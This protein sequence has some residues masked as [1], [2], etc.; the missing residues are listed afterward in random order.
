MAACTTPTPQL[1]VDRAAIVDEVAHDLE[2]YLAPL[3]P[4]SSDTAQD[5]WQTSESQKCSARVYL[6]LQEGCAANLYR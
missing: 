1:T 4:E 2:P 6:G 5:L 3:V